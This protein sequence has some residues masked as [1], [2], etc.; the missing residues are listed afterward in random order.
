MKNYFLH[1]IMIALKSFKTVKNAVFCVTWH[2]RKLVLLQQG[3]FDSQI[4]TSNQVS[5]LL[6][7]YD[8]LLR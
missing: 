4:L 5:V 3:P 7:F 1:A 2:M 6:L 8:D